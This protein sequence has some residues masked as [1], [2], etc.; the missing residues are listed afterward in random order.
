MTFEVNRVT[1]GKLTE[2]WQHTKTDRMTAVRLTC[3]GKT[4]DSF[5]RDKLTDDNEHGLMT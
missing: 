5:I 3:D 1:S 4:D 2:T